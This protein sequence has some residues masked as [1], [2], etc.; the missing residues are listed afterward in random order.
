MSARHFR[1]LSVWLR[2][3][4]QRVVAGVAVLVVVVVVVASM[5][6]SGWHC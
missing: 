6:I 2:P 1:R 3:L 4:W 5:V